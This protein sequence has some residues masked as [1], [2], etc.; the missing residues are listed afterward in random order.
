M[1]DLSETASVRRKIVQTETSVTTGACLLETVLEVLCDGR[2]GVREF[3][4][5]SLKEQAGRELLLSTMS[6]DSVELGLP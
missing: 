3:G 5:P 6:D 4:K 2:L 1:S